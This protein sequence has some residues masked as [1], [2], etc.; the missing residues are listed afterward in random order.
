[1]GIR[2]EHAR[3]GAQG[4]YR[5]KATMSA[6][7]SLLDFISIHSLTIDKAHFNQDQRLFVRAIDQLCSPSRWLWAV[8]NTTLLK[9]AAERAL[10]CRHTVRLVV[11]TLRTT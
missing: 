6:S 1:M 8:E 3:I 7:T 2:A 9:A 11:E 10:L 5:Q 4:W